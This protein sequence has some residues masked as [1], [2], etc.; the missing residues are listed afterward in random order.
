[1]LQWNIWKYVFDKKL[2]NH[3]KGKDQCIMITREHI[4]SMCKEKE[5]SWALMK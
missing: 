1:M 5:E 2:E 3:K 4:V